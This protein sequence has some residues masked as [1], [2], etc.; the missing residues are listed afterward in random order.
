MIIIFNAH[1]TILLLLLCFIRFSKFY[2]AYF[3]IIF[4][5][6]TRAVCVQV[7]PFP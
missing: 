4:V 5:C 6:F 2:K 7:T 1:Q 3:L